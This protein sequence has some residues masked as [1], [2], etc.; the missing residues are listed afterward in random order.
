MQLTLVENFYSW[1]RT[2]L[3]GNVNNN[4]VISQEVNSEGIR[5]VLGELK[6]ITGT[7]LQSIAFKI[8]D[9]Y[10][11]WS[12]LTLS[13]L[14]Y[15]NTNEQNRCTTIFRAGTDNTVTQKEDYELKNKIETGLTYTVAV[16]HAKNGLIYNLVIYNNAQENKEISEI[17]LY[18]ILQTNTEGSNAVYGTFLLGRVTLD[19]PEV[20]APQ[21]SK[22][23]QITLEL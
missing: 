20:I 11:S 4:G 7:L 1:A 17:G 18:K 14:G 5:P 19:T 22:T 15:L 10:T 16:S 9:K 23:Y 3:F 6:D 21:A 8:P 13:T 2:V 12:G